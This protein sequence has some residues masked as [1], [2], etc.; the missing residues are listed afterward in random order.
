MALLTSDSQHHS[1][2]VINHLLAV[3][4]DT[5]TFSAESLPARPAK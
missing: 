4:N 2:K 3:Y 5:S 1:Q